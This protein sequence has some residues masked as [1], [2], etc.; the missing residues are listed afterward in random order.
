S[1]ISAGRLDEIWLPLL[2]TLWQNLW[3][4]GGLASVLWSAAARS[5]EIIVAHSHNAYLQLLLDFGVVGA[6]L[7]LAFYVWAWRA[8]RQA[9]ANASSAYWRHFFMGAS[10]CIVLMFVQGISDDR[11]SP[12]ATQVFMWFGIGA[13]I[14]FVRRDA[15]AA[16]VPLEAVA[17]ADH[18]RP[19]ARPFG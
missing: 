2:P 6:A 7:I 1:A 8:V 16:T 17:V 11:F 10:A 5:G 14:G 9:G 3:F 12:S 19:S 18:G 13:A 4:G 15:R